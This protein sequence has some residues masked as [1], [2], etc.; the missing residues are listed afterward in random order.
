MKTRMPA[1]LFSR[2]CRLSGFPL[3]SS[4]CPPP[5]DV[6]TTSEGGRSVEE[7]FIALIV[8]TGLDKERVGQVGYRDSLMY[9]GLGSNHIQLRYL[10]PHPYVDLIPILE[11][12]SNKEMQYNDEKQRTI[13]CVPPLTAPARRLSINLRRRGNQ[14]C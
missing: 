12:I 9:V 10:V 6:I 11:L 7:L 1:R 2:S 14:V 3:L 5:V 13:A 4:P 8:A